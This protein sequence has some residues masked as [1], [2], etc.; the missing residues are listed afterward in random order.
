M[1][2]KVELLS[3]EKKFD[4]ILSVSSSS[5]QPSPRSAITFESTDD[6]RSCSSAD[7]FFV[8]KN[9]DKQVLPKANN[10]TKRE[11]ERIINSDSLVL[12]ETS[13]CSSID[14][15]M[16]NTDKFVDEKELMFTESEDTDEDEELKTNQEIKN[17]ILKN[18]FA[19]LAARNT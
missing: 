17:R 19:S 11:I 14:S 10:S 18:C 12:A 9:T 4:K 5:G 7:D 13:K 16:S 15:K 6:D 1:K 8:T 2:K 3:N